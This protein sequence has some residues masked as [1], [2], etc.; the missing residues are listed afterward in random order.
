MTPQEQVY[1]LS[2]R[3]HCQGCMAVYYHSNRRNDDA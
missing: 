3:E 1:E 2:R